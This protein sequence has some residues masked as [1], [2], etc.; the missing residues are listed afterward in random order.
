MTVCPALLPPWL[1][2]TM[3]ALAV[4][5][6]MILPFPSSPHCAPTKI[7]FA[8]EI[9]N[10]QKIFPMH[11]LGHT[12]DCCRIICWQCVPARGFRKRGGCSQSEQRS[13][14]IFYEI[15]ILGVNKQ[16]HALGERTRPLQ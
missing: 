3:S 4:S 1:R 14:S 8:I 13:A 16:G 9:G 2:T 10:G 15:Q 6:S 7:V 12:R 5:T 11:L